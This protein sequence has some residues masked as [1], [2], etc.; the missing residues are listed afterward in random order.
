[1]N[2]LLYKIR[3]KVSFSVLFAALHL[4]NKTQILLL[5]VDVYIAVIFRTKTGG[6]DFTYLSEIGFWA[7]I[8]RAQELRIVFHSLL[9]LLYR[10]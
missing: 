1:M 2:H 7:L 10:P 6:C 5:G 3:W 8:I 4:N 9:I